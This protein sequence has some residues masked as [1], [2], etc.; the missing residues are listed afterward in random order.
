MDENLAEF[1]P[2]TYLFK[3]KKKSL[4]LGEDQHS[5]HVPKNAKTLWENLMVEVL[6]CR[7]WL[8]MG[9]PGPP[10]GAVLLLSES[11]C[12]FVC[13]FVFTSLLYLWKIV[14]SMN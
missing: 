7:L 13:F 3:K 2:G 11:V 6:F 10:S 14:R 4:P 1:S 5:L 8:V 9:Q 12:E